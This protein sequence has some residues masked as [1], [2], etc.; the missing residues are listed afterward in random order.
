MFEPV[1]SS[2]ALVIQGNGACNPDQVKAAA[3]AQLNID[4]SRLTVTCTAGASSLIQL[5]SGA[6]VSDDTSTITI[7]VSK[8]VLA[9]VGQPPGTTA[10]IITEAATT[11]DL[12]SVGFKKLAA[13]SVTTPEAV[14]ANNKVFDERQSSLSIAAWI[15][16]ACG[17]IAFVALVAVITIFVL[18]RREGAYTEV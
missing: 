13:V 14:P 1:P 18:R 5:Q 7:D 15:G 9:Q 12:S 10:K 6:E 3:S 16:I 17:G 2:N 4:V 11:I 8:D